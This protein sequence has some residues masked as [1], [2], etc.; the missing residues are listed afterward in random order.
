MTPKRS[1]VSDESQQLIDQ[2]LHL[3]GLRFDPFRVLNA[4]QD[5]HLHEYLVAHETFE[6]IR[7]DQVSFAFAPAGGGKSAFRARLAR[8]CRVGEF[9]RRLFPIV[10]MPPETVILAHPSDR[11]ETHLRAICQAASFEL[12]LRL[13]YRPREFIVLPPGVRS[14]I[15][16]LLNEGLPG[17]LP[18][19]LAQLE[20]PDDLLDL[21]QYYDPTARWPAPPDSKMLHSFRRVMEET[22]PLAEDAHPTDEFDAWLELL[23]GPL[24]FEAVYLLVDGIDAYPETVDDP[25]AALSLLTPLFNRAD[26][27]AERRLFLKAFLPSE[28]E[29]ALRKSYSLLTSRSTIGIMEWTSELLVELL[30]SRLAAA[31]ETAPASLDMLC[32]PGFRGADKLVVEG[33]EPLPRKV[34]AFVEQMFS[35]HVRRAGPRGK[36][37]RAD[38]EATRR[39]Y[40]QKRP[41]SSSG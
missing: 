9:G 26:D 28:L 25:Q 18:H 31:T 40:T 7:D 12:L 22:P 11:L 37:S 20:G 29:S 10:Y 15:R 39:W 4:S 23:L 8:Y 30:K 2:W 1:A 19:Y 32:D 41:S 16:W 34:V 27:W 3:L 5:P 13:A 35:E 6:V 17:P 33:L 14:L 38:L 21:A 24:G 36:L